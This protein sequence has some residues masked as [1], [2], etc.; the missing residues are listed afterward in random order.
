VN[1]GSMQSR[2]N[3]GAPNSRVTPNQPVIWLMALIVG[4][5]GLVMGPD[6]GGGFF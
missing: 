1:E 6:C 3:V 5:V 2:L 4:A